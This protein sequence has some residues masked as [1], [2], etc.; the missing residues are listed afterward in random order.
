M[1]KQIL[2][3]MGT[4][5]EVI[6][7]APVA[8][9][10]QRYRTLKPLV[11][12]SGQHAHMAGQMLEHF[13]LTAD[14][15]FK[16]PRR[17]A[18]LTAFIS[19]ASG[20]LSKLIGVHRPDMIVVQGDTTSAMLGAVAG[21][22]EQIPVAHVEAGLRSFDLRQPF[23]EEF[24]RRI[25]SIAADLNFC[26]TAI[27]AANLRR[28]GISGKQ[29]HVVGNSCI[30]ALLWT[31][32][33]RRRVSAFTQ[34]RRGILVTA[35][36][37]ENWDAGITALC[38]VLRRIVADF[39]DTEILLPVHKN[40]IVQKIIRKELV[41]QDRVRLVE[42]MSYHAFA[43]AMKDAFL[44]ISDS[45]GVQE[46]A[47][48]L[49]TPVLVTRNVTERPEVLKGGTVKLVGTSP[50]ILWTEAT[51]LLSDRS[52]YK[53]THVARFPFGKGDAGEKIATVIRDY[54]RCGAA[55]VA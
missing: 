8:M 38:R 21:F 44:I 53:Q 30:D 5:P 15:V 29:L 12:L 1:R 10:L 20:A 45:G 47:L 33:H 40:P 13:G 3:L 17:T 28:E 18:N 31:L 25:I 23:P 14:Y 19:G 7:L 11:C 43:W 34:G 9:A 51:K 50:K 49:G 55:S 4:R 6:K 22:Y 35:H 36:R 24:N 2:L 41:G 54:L 32:K 16:T 42:P 37:R 48:A 27:S 52:R 39:H 46:E 26:P